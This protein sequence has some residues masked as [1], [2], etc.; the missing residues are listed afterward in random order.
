MTTR[1]AQ[2]PSVT[3]DGTEIPYDAFDP[4]GQLVVDAFDGNLL[5]VRHDGRPTIS[6]DGLDL[7]P[8]H[9][10]LELQADDDRIDDVIAAIDPMLEE[11]L[12]KPRIKIPVAS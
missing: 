10:H 5:V 1:T 12:T 6:D 4:I 7:V 8:A 9:Y 11:L 3:A 2:I